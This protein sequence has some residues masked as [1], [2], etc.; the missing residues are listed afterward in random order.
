[1]VVVY[2]KYRPQRFSEIVG[3]DHIVEVLTNAITKHRVAHGY[4][5]IGPRGTGKTTT[6]RILAKALNCKQRKENDAEPCGKCEHC[7][8]VANGVFF[9]L[10]EID[11]ASNRG[12]DEIRSLK[13]E[14]R[15]SLSQTN[16]K[17]FILDEAHSLTK[18]AA[19]ALLKTLEEPPA[20]TTF[21]L[22]T[23]EP[24]KI[25]PTIKSRLQVLP[26]KHV[27]LVDIVK[28]LEQLAKQEG[29]AIDAGVLKA[30]ALNAS[31]SLRDAESNLAKVLSLGKKKII[32]DDVRQ[33]L[34]I[35]DEHVAVR[36]VDLLVQK[37]TSA[38]FDFVRGIQ[39]KGIEPKPF[40]RTLLEYMRKIA[41]LKFAPQAKT[42][43]EGYLTKEDISI[44]IRQAET[45]SREQLLSMITIFLESL[46]DVEKYPQ[47]QMAL[48]V[49]II[50]LLP[51]GRE[52]N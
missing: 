48:E 38:L 36:F 37:D 20:N 15:V 18:D 45:V 39:E 2:R 25:L 33:T 26:F 35:V 42:E 14:V 44:I 31:G 29:V 19:N 9:D 52:G 3:Q 13:E 43:L 34:G 51:H 6:A 11:A 22:I 23:T 10:I 46:Q 41:L 21:I 40:L 16:W 28:R 7:L 24:E 27:T 12:I 30:I 8:A 4:L 17:V 49:A 50:K 5:F 1:M 32:M 47:S